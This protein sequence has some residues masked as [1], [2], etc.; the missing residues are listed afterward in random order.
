MK[1]DKEQLP[2][3]HVGVCEDYPQLRDKNPLL[4]GQTE[5]M[6]LC[7]RNRLHVCT[8]YLSDDANWYHHSQLPSA[9]ASQSSER[10]PVLKD[11]DREEASAAK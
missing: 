4:I 6:P 2:A 7:K 9:A 10:G 5:S 8:Y 11:V 1:P 3:V